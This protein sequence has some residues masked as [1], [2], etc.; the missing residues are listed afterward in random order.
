MS[1]TI[2]GD[3]TITG[4]NIAFE[5]YALVVDQKADGVGGGTFTSGAWR[6]RDLNTEL[7]DPDSI[8]TVSNN[9]FTL[10]AGTYRVRAEAPVYAV[11]RHAIKLTNVTDSTDIQQGRSHYTA[12]TMGGSNDAFLTARFTL[13]GTKALAIY[14]RANATSPATFGL[15]VDF[16]LGDKEIYCMVEIFKEFA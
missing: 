4:V 15:G 11:N 9:E 16:D 3:G 13:T 7:F 10:G 2:N 5:S 6:K 14:H 8:V 1:I 12:D